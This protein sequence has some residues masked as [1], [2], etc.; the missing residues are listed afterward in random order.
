[1][2]YTGFLLNSTEQTRMEAG[3]PVRSYCIIWGRGGLVA[4]TRMAVKVVRGGRSY[5]IFQGRVSSSISL[6][7]W[8]AE[9]SH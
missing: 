4:Q 8:Y 2:N 7:M 6:D 5:I 3:R 1:M 9:K